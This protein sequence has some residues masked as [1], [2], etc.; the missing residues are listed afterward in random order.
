MYGT[1]DIDAKIGQFSTGAMLKLVKGRSKRGGRCHAF[2]EDH[3]APSGER[4]PTRHLR[5]IPVV[6]L[7]KFRL[8]LY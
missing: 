8:P 1:G 3:M 6:C 7:L 2:K 5:R 4:I